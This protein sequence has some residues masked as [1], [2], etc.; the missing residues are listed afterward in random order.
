MYSTKISEAEESKI[1]SSCFCGAD[2][3]RLAYSG[4]E[5]PH[6]VDL[7]KTTPLTRRTGRQGLSFIPPIARACCDS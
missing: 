7:D 6:I 4:T 5:Y 3:A 1:V 2:S